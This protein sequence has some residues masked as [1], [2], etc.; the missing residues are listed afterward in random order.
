MKISVVCKIPFYW[1]SVVGNCNITVKKFSQNTDFLFYNFFCSFYINCSKT[2]YLLS[3]KIKNTNTLVNTSN[4][5][6]EVIFI[7]I[8]TSVEKTE[9]KKISEYSKTKRN[10][11]KKRQKN[12]VRW[13]RIIFLSNYIKNIIN[14]S[15]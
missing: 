12:F 4:C 11:I 5:V 14:T 8:P 7:T 13:L 15:V 9:E 10:K 3:G 2:I 6:C 1:D